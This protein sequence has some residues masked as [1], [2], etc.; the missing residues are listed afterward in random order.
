MKRVLLVLVFLLALAVVESGGSVAS[1]QSSE[2]ASDQPIY[3]YVDQGGR[4]IFT[5]DLSR[6]PAEDRPFAKIVEL[7]A[8]VTLP[9][10]TPRP[11][12]KP[13]SFST[14]LREWFQSQPAGYR[15]TL[16]GVLPP[17]I[18]GLW[19]LNFFRKRSE[20]LFV[21]MS[22][23]LGMLGLVILSGYLC[24]FIFVQ[25]QAGKLLGTVPG[26][27]DLISSPKQRAEELKRDE[28]DRLKTIEDIANQ[29]GDNAE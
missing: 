28:A 14:R 26:R 15:L 23:R 10:P 13:P 20:S 25:N 27:D 1:P 12:A 8:A 29:K 16:V 17:L 7:P 6:I 4:T 2:K 21:K 11:Q 9:A 19:V 22:L 5:N 24:Y 3:R 18:L